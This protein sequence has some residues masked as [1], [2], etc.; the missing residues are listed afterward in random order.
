MSGRKNRLIAQSKKSFGNKESFK[1][2]FVG[3]A[4]AYE[5]KN[6]FHIFKLSTFRSKLFMELFNTPPF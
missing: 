5:I 2:F 6:D 4:T 3:K 1:F